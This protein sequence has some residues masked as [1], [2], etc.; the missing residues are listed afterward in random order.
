[1]GIAHEKGEIVRVVIEGNV[2]EACRGER[3]LCLRTGHDKNEMLQSDRA[4]VNKLPMAFF[5]H[6]QIASLADFRILYWRSGLSCG[7]VGSTGV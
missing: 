2:S 1:L 3:E 4:T 7:Q 5:I 6:W